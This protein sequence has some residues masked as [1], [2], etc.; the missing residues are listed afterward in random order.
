MKQL[1]TTLKSNYHFYG[2][3]LL[4]L[5]SCG[6][7]LLTVSKAESFISLN[8]FH[9]FSLNVFFVNYTFFGDGI[10]AISLCALLFYRKQ[11]KLAVLILLAYLSSG[12]FTQI[13]KNCIYAPRPRIYFEASQYL[14]HLDNFGN[15]GG[16]SSSFPSGHTTSA[17][18]LATVLAVHFKNKFTGIIL[19]IAAALV[20]YS[21]VYLAQ[22]FPVDV[23]FGAFIGISFATLSIVLMNSRLRIRLPKIIK[24]QV[25]EWDNK[26]PHTAIY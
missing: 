16:G 11:K 17:F 12:L 5:I 23:L 22:H 19:F 2:S 26:L 10:F 8:S 4:F 21:R 24:R 20:G 25:P 9:C 13:L 7:I 14:Y 15:S 6:L 1:N 18:A 3:S